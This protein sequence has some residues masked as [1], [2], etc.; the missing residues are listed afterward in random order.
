MNPI[1]NLLP[2]LMQ[3]GI[4]N[5]DLSM[6]DDG[7]KISILDALGDAYL[8]K[9]NL[10]EAIKAF[11]ITHNQHRLIE[12]GREFEALRKFDEALEAYKLANDFDKIE[13]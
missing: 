2:A 5:I 8:K 13:F 4:D 3:K 11:V 10:P 9:G 1:N 12:I 7:S 6:L